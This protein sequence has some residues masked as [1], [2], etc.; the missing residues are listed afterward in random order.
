MQLTEALQTLN[1]IVRAK[2]L[3]CTNGSDEDY[4]ALIVVCKA[5]EQYIDMKDAYELCLQSLKESEQRNRRLVDF[6]RGNCLTSL[7]L[8]RVKER[9]QKAY[10]DLIDSLINDTCKVL[11]EVG[12]RNTSLEVTH[13]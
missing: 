9:G 13:G 1:E 2:A 7:L 4:E 12:V 3:A 6:L 10:R 8:L 11:R 5:A